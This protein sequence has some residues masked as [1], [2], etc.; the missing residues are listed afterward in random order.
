MLIAFLRMFSSFSSTSLQLRTSCP[1]KGANHSGLDFLISKSLIKKILSIRQTQ[2]DSSCL[3]SQVIVDCV[4]LTSKPTIPLSLRVFLRTH[5]KYQE[6]TYFYCSYGQT[7]AFSLDRRQIFSIQFFN[8][9]SF[10]AI[11]SR[12]FGALRLGQSLNVSLSYF[13]L[14]FSSERK[15]IYNVFEISL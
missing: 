7:N 4:N 8:L 3:D 10:A 2:I 5:P 13:V 1:G 6:Y 9:P 11:F 15:R 14:C 12:Y